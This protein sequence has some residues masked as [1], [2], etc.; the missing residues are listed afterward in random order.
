MT[1]VELVVASGLLAMFMLFIF[2]LLSSTLDIWR[3]AE[4]RRES[5]ESLSGVARVIDTDLMALDGGPRGDMLCE[6]ASFDADGDGS[7]DSMWPRLRFVRSVSAAEID[8][9]GIEEA[10]LDET[11]GLM[12][13]L[14]MVVPGHSPANITKNHDRLAEGIL[15]R[16][17]HLVGTPGPSIF[18]SGFI[19]KRNLAPA[20]ATQEVV[21]G[22]LWLGMQFATQTT[23]IHDGW[24]LGSRMEDASASWDAWNRGR[25]DMTLTALNEPGAGMPRTGDRALLPRRV[26]IEIELE[27][28]AEAKRRTRLNLSASV[29]DT[30]LEVDDTTRLPKGEDRYLK[31]GSEWMELKSVSSGQ[32][33][34]R[35][36]ARGSR[37]VAHD[38]GELVH[39]GERI[40]REIPI[41]LH[42]DDWNMR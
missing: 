31:V 27:R 4:V 19:N 21:G 11:Q 6:W 24:S 16:G 3:K 14:W 23:L 20:D 18:D 33:T 28:P 34:V 17:T 7:G 1:L 35:R 25:P 30:G 10:P 41:A 36:G 12:E 2:Q 9:M 8:R 37:A 15:L 22:V 42:H 5:V 32:M 39:W 38:A 13:V 29:E 40:V 26:R